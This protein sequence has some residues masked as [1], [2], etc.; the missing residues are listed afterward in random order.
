MER[1]GISQSNLSGAFTLRASAFL[2]LA[3][4]LRYGFISSPLAEAGEAYSNS[5]AL[6]HL[7]IPS[8]ISVT[9]MIAAKST[10]RLPVKRPKLG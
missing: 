7:H 9:P 6:P 10:Q 4:A 2:L 1:N 8:A 5:T 3:G